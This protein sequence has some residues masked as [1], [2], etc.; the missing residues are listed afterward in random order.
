[1]SW[2]SLLI[3]TAGVLAACDPEAQD[4]KADRDRI[5]GPWALVSTQSDGKTVSADSLK[6]RD[7]RMVFEG[8]RVLAK[9]G[10]MSV[11]LGTFALD[12]SRTPKA[13]DRTYE[14]GTPRRGIYTLEGETLTICIAG[15][16]KARPTA[17]ATQ[18][19]DGLSLLVYTRE[20]R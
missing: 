8:E 18:P 2:Q 5:Q 14:D 9:M 15:L 4:R 16:G 20:K 7:V 13:Y 1:M 19:G 11:T 3:A 17:F 10:D 6:A 12:P